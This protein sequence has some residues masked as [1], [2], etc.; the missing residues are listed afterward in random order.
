MSG[1]RSTRTALLGA[2]ALVLTGLVTVAPAG[3]EQSDAAP[4]SVAESTSGSYV[5]VMQADPLV[6]DFAPEDLGTPK[7]EAEAAEIVASHEEVL[8]EVGAEATDLVQ[9]YTN[10]VN[11]FSALI[12]HDEAEKLAA[13]KSVKLVQPDELRHLQTDSSG[14]FMGL[15]GK[16]RAWASGVTGEGVVVGVID[17]GIWPEHPSFADDG[18]YDRPDNLPLDE[19]VGD[20]CDFGNTA[21]NT[22]DKPFRC[23]NKLIGARQML[24]TYRALEGAEADEFDSARDDDGHG[25][26]TASTASGNAGVRATIFGRNLGRISGVAPR[27]HVIA[28]KG[29]G[30]LGG[31]GSDLAAAID[32]AVAD[33]VDVINYSVGGG[34]SLTGAE[35]IAYLFAADA[36]V[37]V[38]TSA[39]NSGP[40]AATIGGPASV[41]WVTTVGASTQE[42]FLAGAATL[43]RGG[44]HGRDLTVRG[45]SVTPGTGRALRLVDGATVGNE[46][47]LADGF[48]TSVK[49]AVVLCKRGGNGRAEK[50]AAVAAAGGKG[51]ILY[52]TSNVDDLFT[53]N[54]A[55]PSLAVDL[56]EG[57]VVKRYIASTRNPRAEIRTGWTTRWRAAPSMTLFSSRGPDPVAED[58]IKPDVTAPGLQIL[59]GNSPFPDPG[60]VQGE[61]F[62]AIGGTSMSSPQVAGLLALL[63]QVHPDWT[64]AMAK[65]ALMTSAHQDV[66]DNDR[67]SP[68]DPFDM[69]AG[70][71]DPG[72]ASGRGSAFNP[73]LVYDAGFTEYLGFLCDAEPSVFAN[74]D[75]TCSSLAAHDVPTTAVDLNLASIGVSSVPGA[76]TITRTVT[77]VADRT[78][79]WRVSVDKPTGF[80]VSVSP[81]RITLAP[82]DS[83]SYTVTFTNRR[84]PVDTWR[85]GSLT[86]RA[87]D[88]RAYSPIA[89]QGTLFEAPDAAQGSGTSGSGSVP[90]TFGYTGPYT[91]AAHGLVAD[92]PVAGEISQDPD[93]TYPSGDDGAGV[94]E[95]PFQL[96]GTAFARWSLSIPGDS[97]LDLY[98]E[99]PDG[100]VVASSTN[101]GTDEQIDLTAPADGT[102]T[103]V[104]HGWAVP[105]EPLPYSVSFW[106]VP[107]AAGGGSLTVTSAPS[108]ATIG[109]TADVGY[110]WS[111]L[112]AGGQFLGAVS[113]SDAS[114][115]IGLTLI[116]VTS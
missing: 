78:L 99:G 50:S 49:G 106:D 25:T 34:P 47:C 115:V 16:G 57:L 100:S 1:A 71:V 39:G 15:T 33:G 5:V 91:A 31:Y 98:L 103:L 81:K 65:S 93:Q 10:A 101:G 74:P 19:T 12:S 114:G 75:A 102:Y 109:A 13:Q 38:A 67:T 48:T 28:Y 7:A 59:A 107:A 21:H 56:R 77:S 46:L 23:N 52:N 4:P 94:D 70:H 90:V 36:G 41:P 68:A 55:V 116:E 89:V 32:Q 95:I 11:G 2:A 42:R 53:D 88:Y 17:S 61:L 112:P 92:D 18:S 6:A 104:V 111:G 37:F 54:H 63:K 86:W 66:R 14:Q 27:A 9:S 72:K 8:E 97:D 87:G 108:S 69:G 64:P 110:S 30:N 105:T 24:Q 45:A 96:S 73:G 20:P 76:R 26:H 58:I 62:Q 3:A 51:M 22:Q 40:G 44:T 82:G 113:H 60:N 85:F 80:D 83:A 84:A 29:L 43:V 35:D 79:T